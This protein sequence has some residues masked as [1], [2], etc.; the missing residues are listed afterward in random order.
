MNEPWTEPTVDNLRKACADFERENQT[1]EKALGE[2][3]KQFP[4]NLDPAHV[5]LKVVTLNALYST[6]IPLY[7]ERIPTVWDVVDHI[8]ELKIDADLGLGSEDLVHKIA[9][10][11]IQ[12]KERRFNYS[13]AT[14]YCSWHR[15]DSYPIWDSRA[16]GYLWQLRNQE[17]GKQGGLR[18]FEHKELWRYPEFKKVVTEFRDHYGLQEFAFKQI[19]EFLWTEGS[20]LFERKDKRAANASESPH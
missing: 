13:F 4:D 15:P 2:L 16:D 3:F 9:Y 10:T 5:L 7:S 19:D 14:K 18:Q 12:G 20:K 1:L 6:Q 8:V 11:E 17:K